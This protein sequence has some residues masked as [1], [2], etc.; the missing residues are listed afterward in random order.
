MIK[1]INLDRL[2][3]KYIEKYVFENVGKVKPE[4]IE[5]KIPVLYEEFGNAPQKDLDGKTPNGYYR[6]FNPQELIAA[7]KTHL[8]QDVEVSD[9]LIEAITANPDS[10]KTVK[11]ELMEEHDEQF[12]AYLMNILSDLKGDR[13]SVV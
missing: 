1:I 9:F 6:Q 7:L 2:F 4:E 5:N 13:K 12:T 10:V 8:E 11:S 3:D